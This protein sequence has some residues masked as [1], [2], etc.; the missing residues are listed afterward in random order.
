M[1]PLSNIEYNNSTGFA[2]FISLISI[3]NNISDQISEAFGLILFKNRS[4]ILF[5]L[6]AC[7][8]TV[9]ASDT[10]KKTSNKQAKIVK[11]YAGNQTFDAIDKSGKVYSKIPHYNLM[12][13]AI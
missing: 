3:T 11:V 2:L 6:L 9:F 5:L 7:S 1:L 12:V 13:L 8:V 4:N 10:T